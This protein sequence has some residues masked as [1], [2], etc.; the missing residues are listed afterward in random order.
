M[1]RGFS[2]DDKSSK[3]T[4]PLRGEIKLYTQSKLN[5]GDVLIVP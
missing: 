4:G 5:F 2:T 3:V 1:A